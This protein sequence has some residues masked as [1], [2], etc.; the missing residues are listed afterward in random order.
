MLIVFSTNISSLTGLCFKPVSCRM[1][2]PIF[3]LQILQLTELHIRISHL[4]T[5]MLSYFIIYFY[6]E[7]I[8]I[9]RQVVAKT[10]MILKTIVGPDWPMSQV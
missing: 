10:A 9:N 4:F 8:Q 1:Q 6:P 5:N 7:Q 2:P 3:N